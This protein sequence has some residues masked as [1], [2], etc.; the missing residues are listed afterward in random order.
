MPSSNHIVELNMPSHKVWEFVSDLNN[1]APLMPGYIAH[2]NVNEKE[3]TWDFLGDFGFM[4]KKVSLKVNRI[5][6]VEESM[7]TFDLEGINDNFDG[8]GSFEVKSL[9]QDYTILTGSLDIS[10]GG[11]MGVMINNVL[12]TFVPQTTTE[13]VEAISH[14]IEGKVVS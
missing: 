5:I 13:L 9:N 3:A 12:K 8:S 10:S 11:F 4:K 14:E 7:I 2:E 6:R 1:W